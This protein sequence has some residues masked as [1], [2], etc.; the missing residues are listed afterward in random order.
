MELE[1]WENKYNNSY[2]Y[3]NVIDNILTYD[4]NLT[5]FISEF[6]TDNYEY[7]RP[8]KKYSAF[9]Q[10]IKYI[11]FRFFDD[12]MHTHDTK[13]FEYYEKGK[14]LP[15]LYAESFL[16]SYDLRLDFSEFMD[17]KSIIT[18]QDIEEYHE[19]LALIGYIEELCETLSH[20]VFY[21]LF[22]N[23][24]LLI[25]FNHIVSQYVSDLDPLDFDEEDNF[26]DYF[27]DIG[28]LKRVLIPSWCKK[29]VFY[30]EKG[31]CCLCGTDVTGTLRSDDNY[32]FDHMVPL[33][34]GG[35]NDVSNVQLLCSKCNL[36]KGK[37]DVITSNYYFK[38]Y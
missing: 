7:L 5:G 38:W 10:F 23:R 16:D 3:S 31:R 4:I 18:W 17:G 30:R 32:H 11:I 29:A 15:K 27:K 20:E 19:E 26:K 25:R 28:K 24:D 33:F 36:S 8:F 14:E 12:D 6:F 22:N 1:K 13:A 9:H 35:I 2:Y 34:Q 37:R 21:V